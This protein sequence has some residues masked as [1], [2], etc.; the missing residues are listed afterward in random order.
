MAQ[1]LPSAQSQHQ[2]QQQWADPQSSYGVPDIA[3]PSPTAF[4]EMLSSAATEQ[5]SSGSG[6]MPPVSGLKA[7]AAENAM[8]STNWAATPSDMGNQSTGLT[9]FLSFND[10]QDARPAN[11]I[12]AEP[13]RMDSNGS[14]T[15]QS[16]QSQSR[17][18]SNDVPD[19]GAGYLNQSPGIGEIPRQSTFYSFSTNTGNGMPG[20]ENLNWPPPVGPDGLQPSTRTEGPWRGVETVESVYGVQGLNEQ[21]PDISMQQNSTDSGTAEFNEAMQQQLL[22]DL[23]WPGWPPHLPEPNIVNDL[24][25]YLH[26]WSSLLIPVSTLSSISCRACHGYCTVHA[27]SRDSLFRL[28]IQISLILRSFTLFALPQLRPVIHQ[29]TSEALVVNGLTGRLR[30]R[31]ICRLRCGKPPLAKKQYRA[32]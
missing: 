24:S 29:S 6:F 25:V 3:A 10:N 19:V 27:C 18:S 14:G 4:L 17:K 1:H 12:R 28:L 9:P 7:G 11:E 20:T 8:M 15:S 21:I 13:D 26:I 2:P 5:A 23:F 16:M 30:M 32:A 22:L 31:G